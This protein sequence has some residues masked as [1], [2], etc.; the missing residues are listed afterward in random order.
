MSNCSMSR[1]G[2]PLRAVSQ[3][4]MLKTQSTWKTVFLV[5]VTAR[6]RPPRS[7]IRTARP[8]CTRASVC[9]TQV[10]QVVWFRPTGAPGSAEELAPVRVRVGLRRPDHD[11][12]AR[13]PDEPVARLVGGEHRPRE[14][15]RRCRPAEPAVGSGSWLGWV[16]RRHHGG[17]RHGGGREVVRASNSAAPETP[18]TRTSSSVEPVSVLGCCRREGLDRGERVGPGVGAE[19]LR[20]PGPRSRSR[21]R[22]RR[23]GRGRGRARAGSR[24][25]TR[26]RSRWC[27]RPRR[28]TPA[29]R[30]PRR[31]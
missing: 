9:S 7:T 14:D 16:G 24:P 30:S 8:S 31:R 6:I 26:R 5:S 12:S 19:A 21:A 25:R 27:R 10:A 18:L 15:R 29:P 4:T 20:R 17:G 22:P 23:A 28:R 13:A 11:G 3:V 1:H 2:S